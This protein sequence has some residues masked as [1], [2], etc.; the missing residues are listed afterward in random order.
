M[1]DTVTPTQADREQQG[2]LWIDNIVSSMCDEAAADLSYTAD[3]M[4][5]AFIAGAATQ[6]AEIARREDMAN[7]GAEL[8]SAIKDY[9]GHAAMKGWHP[10]DCPSEIVGDLLNALDERDAE[11]ARLRE[12]L[13]KARAALH[14][15]YSD[16]DGE[17][18]DAVELQLARSA[19]DAALSAQPSEQA[20]P[21][22]VERLVI[23]ARTMAFGDWYGEGEDYEVARKEL[24]DASEAFASRVEWPDTP[25]EQEGVE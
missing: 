4:V 20:L 6:A 14:Q 15:H 10:A 9:S 17:P 11:I 5:D 12:A 25:S 7:V 8:M 19:C 24:D 1:T 3:Q 22:D 23:A 16:W 21:N 13:G 18:E 2:W